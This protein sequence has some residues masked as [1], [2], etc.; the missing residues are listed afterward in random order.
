M[1]FVMDFGAKNASDIWI[2]MA[3]RVRKDFAPGSET[4]SNSR[5]L[6]FLSS[7]LYDAYYFA[8]AKLRELIR[9]DFAKAFEKVDALISPTSPVRH[10][11]WASARRVQM[12][13]A[14]IFTIAANLARNMRNQSGCAAKMRVRSVNCGQTAR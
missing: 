9:Q 6:R 14:N 4:T 13:L 3:G 8:R 2:F 7:G 5:S 10:S 11:S 12:Y 1:E